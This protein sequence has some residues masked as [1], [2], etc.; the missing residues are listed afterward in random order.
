MFSKARHLSL[1]HLGAI[2][3]NSLETARTQKTELRNAPEKVQDLR[4]TRVY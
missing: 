3:K 4:H 1:S 2:P